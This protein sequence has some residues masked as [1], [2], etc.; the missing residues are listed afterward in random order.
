MS[1]AHSHTG[2]VPPL[3][4]GTKPGRLASI[5]PKV[6][7]EL[8]AEIEKMAADMAAGKFKM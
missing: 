1:S 2:P 5:S 8:K 3:G 6:P 7:A 4:L